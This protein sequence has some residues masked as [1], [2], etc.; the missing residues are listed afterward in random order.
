MANQKPKKSGKK[1]NS[2]PEPK[3][4]L[5]TTAKVSA[6]EAKSAKETKEVKDAKTVKETT[7]TKAVK[8][9]AENTSSKRESIF[10]GFFA[11]K[12]DENENILTIFKSPRIWGALLGE[13][14]GTMLF[15]MLM[16]TLGVQPLYIVLAVLCIYVVIFGI[17]GAN[18][19]PLVTAGM[20]ATRRMSAIR[21]VLYMLAQLLG[22]W[23]GLIIVNAF[24]LGSGTT[25]ELNMMVEVTG[26]TFWGVAL[27]ELLGAIV[28]AF[29]FARA[30]KY[31]RKSA[32]TFAFV[33]TSGITLAVI[34]GIVISQG[35]FAVTGTT[36]MF[37][38]VVALMYQILPTAADNIGELA[39]LAGLAA[40]AYVVFP[41]LGGVIGFYLSDVISRL[42][43]NGFAN[44][45]DE[46]CDGTCKKIA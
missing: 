11:R 37:N 40:A 26:E 10:K 21:G 4:D 17:S 15:T 32:L 24:R 28:I 19:N 39:Q 29:C 45:Y 8:A 12:Y 6:K 25:Q 34:F 42:A 5:K 7:T 41:I 38:P 30:L 20:M 18:L 1:D 13:V 23:I 33:V 14:I 22:A 44:T 27:V 46:G 9:T 2:Q 31:A 43:G 16:L 36:F 35:F 3:K